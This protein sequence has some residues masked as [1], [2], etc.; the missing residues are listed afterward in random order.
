MSG[1]KPWDEYEIKARYIPTFVSVVPLVQFLLLVMD[2]IF[3]SELINNISWMMV[4]NLSLAFIV[5]LFMVQIQCTLGK[6]WIEESVFGKGGER[7]PTTDMLLYRGGLIS[8]EGKERLRKKI[9]DFSDHDFSSETEEMKDP[10]NA[11]LQAR[12]AVGYVR[13]AV[14]RGA[15]TFQYNIRYGFV[16]NFIAGIVWNVI[17]CMGCFIFY[18]INNNWKPAILFIVYL[19]ICVMLFAYKKRILERLAYSYA[20]NLFNEFLIRSK[21]V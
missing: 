9:S 10:S 7:F 13:T 19:I 18:G 1:V 14:G 20:D 8:R 5:M 21:G 16:R 12:E 4:A 3:W 15:M 11:R 2:R 6:H 17:G